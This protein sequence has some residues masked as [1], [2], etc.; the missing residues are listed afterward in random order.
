MANYQAITQ[1][2]GTILLHL[3][4]SDGSIGPAVQ[5]LPVPKIL[6]PQGSPSK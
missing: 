5:I 6:K 1:E 4:K 2:D 3:L